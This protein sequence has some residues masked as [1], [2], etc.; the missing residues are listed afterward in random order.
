MAFFTILS[1][2]AADSVG[3]AVL[4]RVSAAAR[5]LGLCVRIPPGTWKFFCCECCLLSGRGL[6]DELVTR[7]EESYR[8]WCVVVC[9]LETSR[10]RR[11][12]PTGGCRAKKQIVERK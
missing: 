8:L 9:D 10:M 1:L 5:L 6:C 2:S 4:R 7:P 11:S 3:R 12:W